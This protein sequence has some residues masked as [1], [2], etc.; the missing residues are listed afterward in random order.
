MV[1]EEEWILTAE[2]FRSVL[3]SPSQDC[4]AATVISPLLKEAIK[5]Y[6]DG[7]PP[8]LVSWA[9]QRRVGGTVP[10]RTVKLFKKDH[11]D[12]E[13]L[14][15]RKII[16]RKWNEKYGFWTLDL[17]GKR[18][19]LRSMSGGSG[20]A[21]YQ[22]WLDCLHGFDSDP[23]AHAAKSLLK[24]HARGSVKRKK[25][26]RDEFDSRFSSPQQP[27]L[28]AHNFPN[29]TPRAKRSA[30]TKAQM[31]IKDVVEHFL[32]PFVKSTYHSSKADDRQNS[33]KRLRHS[34]SDAPAI[35]S[36]QHTIKSQSVQTRPNAR[37]SEPQHSLNDNDADRKSRRSASENRRRVYFS[38]PEP[39]TVAFG[40]KRTYDKFLS[41]GHKDIATALKRRR[42]EISRSV[43]SK[44]MGE[45]GLATESTHA[46][47]PS[48]K[49]SLA[50]LERDSDGST[51]L[52]D[53]ESD[54]EGSPHDSA[55][56]GIIHSGDHVEEPAQVG[57]APSEIL[58][59]PT[60]SG[61]EEPN[62][63]NLL[64]AQKLSNTYF[65]ITVPPNLDFK[66][67]KLS[68]CATADDVTTAILQ[69]FKMENQIDQIDSFRF[70]FEWLPANACYRTLLI[71]PNQMSSSF[72]YVVK[73]IDKADL[74]ATESEC[75]LG[76]DILVKNSA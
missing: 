22:N 4:T 2:K 74:W 11:L 3:E 65:L 35:G 58:T 20:G 43:P 28:E 33:N 15:E 57:D 71:E 63:L 61:D 12:P 19:I 68:S 17:N 32:T 54:V 34:R 62:P 56:S 30:K 9:S 38:T 14:R 53:A 59:Q 24:L 47:A 42:E 1:N 45:I 64:S 7:F 48:L 18:L 60:T 51:T 75:Y 10:D 67:A 52:S 16:Y 70:K 39:T 46:T 36:S 37:D 26:A 49:G 44:R 73:R 23:I 25:S 8:F 69:P 29:G 72:D 21:R 31:K 66:I 76:V 5:H 27:T 40:S 41:T 55:Y 13:E 50:A 6:R